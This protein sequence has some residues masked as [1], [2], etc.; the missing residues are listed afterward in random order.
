MKKLRVSKSSK[1]VRRAVEEKKQEA[2][3][4]KR[5]FGSAEGQIVFKRGWD[6]PMTKGELDEFLGG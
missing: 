4:A 5:V 3:P 2:L 6:A 1:P